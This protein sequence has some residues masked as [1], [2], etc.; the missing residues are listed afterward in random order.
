MKNKL[1]LGFIFIAF[2]AKAHI[3]YNHH[4]Q[5]KIAR[6]MVDLKLNAASIIEF[7]TEIPSFYD[8]STAAVELKRLSKLWMEAM[9]HHD[10]T[11]LNELMSPDY[12]L[13]RWD[14]KV[15]ANRA[16]WLQNLFQQ[17]KITYWEQS[18]FGAQVYGDVAIVTSLYSWKGSAFGKEFDSKGYLTDVW[19]RH[20]NSWQVISRTNGV[21]EDSKTLDTK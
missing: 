11:L 13:Q 19:V 2:N 16:L 3:P 7:N 18:D 9:L 20:H 17:I 5:L 12:R 21:F 10:S 6:Q 1:L 4:F 14:G 8:D 15:M